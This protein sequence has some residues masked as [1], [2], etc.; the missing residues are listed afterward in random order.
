MNA[1]NAESVYGDS[2]YSIDN[3]EDADGQEQV[4][5][6]EDDYYSDGFLDD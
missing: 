4:N 3:Y 2:N 6:A 5:A 1:I